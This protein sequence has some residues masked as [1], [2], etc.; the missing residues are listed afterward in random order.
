MVLSTQ[1]G[2][3]CAVATCLLASVV[4][5]LAL[6]CASVPAISG[7]YDYFARPDDGDPWSRKIARWQER[8]RYDRLDP[9]SWTVDEKLLAPADVAEP[10][11]AGGEDAA[12]DLQIKYAAFRAQ[13]RRTVAR[14]TAA[15][16]Q[17][18]SRQHY[19]PDGPIDRWATL[20]ETLERNGDDCDGLELL[21]YN[22]LRE[23]G[24]GADEVYR[25]IVYRPSDGQH[26]MV[27]FWFED[28]NDPWVIDPTGAMT[29]G[30]PRMSE[31]AEWRPLKVF[32]LDV[33]FT[34]ER[35]TFAHANP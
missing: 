32:G 31:V 2:R 18:Q 30:M 27:T 17:A 8:E 24:F 21:T 34:V 7:V 22:L 15:W 1:R 10:G 29:S 6:G 19:I 14:E 12:G 5:G 3:R 25:A 16:I 26:H 13:Q 11:E 20:A 28:R 35:R 9:E 33:D 23:L 4:L